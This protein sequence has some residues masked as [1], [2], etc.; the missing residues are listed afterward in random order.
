MECVWRNGSCNQLVSLLLFCLLDVLAYPQPVTPSSFPIVTVSGRNSVTIG[1]PS[2]SGGDVSSFT[3][4]EIQWRPVSGEWQTATIP[5]S[6]SSYTIP[7]EL[8]GGVYDIRVRATSAS[9]NSLYT[10][11]VQISLPNLPTVRKYSGVVCSIRAQWLISLFLVRVQWAN[12]CA[13]AK[14]KKKK[15]KNKA[16]KINM[17]AQ[18]PTHAVQLLIIMILI[19]RHFFLGRFILSALSILGI[20]L[21]R[22]EEEDRERSFLF[23]LSSIGLKNWTKGENCGKWPPCHALKI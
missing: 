21:E 18:I 7:G 9:G 15:Q 22:Q 12:L 19:T 16:L 3:S 14:T 6:S 23:T 8:A 13:R 10:W 2:L 11:P 5:T 20:G 17:S 4:W 1:T